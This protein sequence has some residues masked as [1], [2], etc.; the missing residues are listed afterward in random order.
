MLLDTTGH[1]FLGAAAVLALSHLAGVLAVRLGQPRVIGEV[2]AG[3]TL[4][5]SVLGALSPQTAAWLFPPAILPMLNG[6]AQ[7]GLAL[8]MFGT[9]QEL[10]S[11][12]VRG[13]SRQGLTISQA[14]LLLPFGAGALV[15]MPLAGDY[16]PAGTSPTAFV[17]FVGCAVSITAFPVLARMLE[18]LDISRTRPGR[19]SLFAAAVG[20]G[21]SWLALSAVLALAHGSGPMDAVMRALVSVA[22]IAICLGPVRRLVAVWFARR[23]DRVGPA[24]LTVTLVVS[25]GASAAMTAALGLHQLIGAFLVGLVWPAGNRAA[26]TAAAPLTATAKTVLLPF[27]FMGYGL[28]VDLGALRLSTGAGLVLAALLAAAVLAKIGGTGLGARYAGLP[29]TESLAVGILMNTRGLTELVVL[30]IGHEAHIIDD[31]MFA[32]LTVVALVTTLMTAPLLRL[33]GTLPPPAPA[34]APPTRARGEE[35]PV[36]T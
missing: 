8:F 26:A 30:Q 17:L 19:L 10:A 3:I 21:G 14:S 16:A 36:G 34:P 7:I 22:V 1:F 31:R 35:S 9:G 25:I 4:G 24:T 18:D 20:D 12:R 29:W 6:L 32:L 5:P 11:M 15:A 27:F 28:G 2:G 33:T 13:A 23:A